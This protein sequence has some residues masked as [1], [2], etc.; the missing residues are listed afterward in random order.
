MGRE[1]DADLRKIILDKRKQQEPQYLVEKFASI[2]QTLYSTLEFKNAKKILAYVGKTASGE[3]NTTLLL[4]NIINNEKTSLFLP[5]CKANNEIGLDLYEI[6]NLQTDLEKG[7]FNL[8]EPKIQL[9]SVKIDEIDLI[10]V[11][12]LVFDKYGM[13]LGYGAGYYDSLLKN[14]PPSAHIIGLCLDFALL[15]EPQRLIRKPTDVLI[16]IIITPEQIIKV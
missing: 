9:K 13:R 4:E 11:P 15:P 16:K 8:M 3:F 1:N 6:N 5:R 14:C 12:G 2:V 7:A 10:I